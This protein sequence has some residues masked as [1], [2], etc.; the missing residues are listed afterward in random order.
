MK[1]VCVFKGA[2]FLGHATIKQLLK[3]G[4]SVHASVQSHDESL[5]SIHLHDFEDDDEENIT[6]SEYVIYICSNAEHE[7]DDIM[8]K[9]E[10]AVS[11]NIVHFVIVVPK[12]T[13]NEHWK[14]SLIW[15]YVECHN[16]SCT[17]IKT[18]IPIGH[19]MDI[20]PEQTSIF[21]SLLEG[22]SPDHS[23]LINVNDV[24]SITIK[25]LEDV[26]AKN[27][28]ISIDH[29][30]TMESEPREFLGV[31]LS[32]IHETIQSTIG[33]LRVASNGNEQ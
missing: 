18:G 16:I 28:E 10:Y 33:H 27:K 22:T 17:I 20:H 19:T 3:E 15:E 25:A 31:L 21:T 14:S 7:L 6:D 8:I 2:S 29:T 23:S 1:S 12:N 32:S 24:S 30:D 9:L 11:K 13:I 26:R 5:T 4:Y